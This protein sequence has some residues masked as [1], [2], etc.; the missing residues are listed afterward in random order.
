M[1]IVSRMT[2]GMYGYTQ[3]LG[4]FL[5]LAFRAMLKV[6]DREVARHSDLF[7]PTVSF[8][9]SYAYAEDMSKP[10]DFLEK[11]CPAWCD[12]ILMSSAA[13]TTAVDSSYKLV[14]ADVCMGDHKVCKT[15]FP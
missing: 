2:M 13:R 9:P 11:R 6:F 4:F 5:T 1:V 10:R 14:G 3:S 12:R 8:S 7:E 15:P